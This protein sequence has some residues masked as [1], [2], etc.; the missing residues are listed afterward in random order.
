LE[1]APPVVFGDASA[2]YFRGLNQT[3]WIVIAGLLACALADFLLCISLM[4]KYVKCIKRTKTISNEKLI[5]KQTIST[6]YTQSA[7][8]YAGPEVGVDT[9][10]V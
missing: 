6:V 9:T 4:I 1:P 2:A 5:N 7:S 3:N 8:A 10:Q